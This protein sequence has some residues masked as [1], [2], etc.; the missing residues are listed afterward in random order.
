MTPEALRIINEARGIWPDSPA[1][2]AP[3]PA[4][5]A[6]APPAPCTGPKVVGRLTDPRFDARFIGPGGP[7]NGRVK[8]L[9][10]AARVAFNCP[11][12]ECG[13]LIV[14]PLPPAPDAWQATGTSLAD[15]RLSPSIAHHGLGPRGDPRACWHGFVGL[16]IPGEVTTC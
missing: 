12:G 5:S 8:E 16:H 13:T 2:P 6:P 3:P 4:L 1:A 10:D 9:K 11:C 15:L 7:D 14:I